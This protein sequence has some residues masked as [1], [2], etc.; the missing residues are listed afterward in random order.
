MMLARKRGKMPRADNCAGTCTRR[1]NDDG[2]VGD[3][4][5]EDVEAGMMSRADTCV[6]H[7]IRVP[8]GTK[9]ACRTWLSFVLQ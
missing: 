3:D 5:V 9:C 8:T 4:V 2:D 1:V 7:C 6:D